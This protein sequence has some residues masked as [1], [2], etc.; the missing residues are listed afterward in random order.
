MKFRPRFSL[1][2]LLIATALIALLVGWACSQYRWVQRRQ[3][4]LHAHWHGQQIYHVA[5]VRYDPPVPLTSRIF[6]ER[7]RW[8]LLAIDH[9]YMD[10]A[11]QLFPESKIYDA[12]GSSTKP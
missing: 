10:E 11:K 6:G 12:S 1:R 2:A 5:F 4:F 8:A 9:D 3:E 7:H